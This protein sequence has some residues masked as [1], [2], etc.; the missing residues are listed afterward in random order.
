MKLLTRE[1]VAKRTEWPERM[2]AYVYITALERTCL[3]AMA[4]AA[5]VR[6][7]HYG[8]AG[9]REIDELKAEV[10]RLRAQVEELGACLARRALGGTDAD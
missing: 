7:D 10:A 5:Q 3:A 9:V 1:Q 6:L 4:D 2:S 8:R